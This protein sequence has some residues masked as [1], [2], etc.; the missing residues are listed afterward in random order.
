MR[1][2]RQGGARSVLAIPRRLFLVPPPHDAFRTL[3]HGDIV[4]HSGILLVLT[5]RVQ[6][7]RMSCSMRP[8]R[9]FLILKS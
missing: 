8:K 6:I 1:A 5:L 2:E 9:R 4:E 7:R 3:R